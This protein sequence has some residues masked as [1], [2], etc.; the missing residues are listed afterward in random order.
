MDDQHLPSPTMVDTCHYTLQFPPSQSSPAAL[1]SVLAEVLAFVATLS[2]SYI[3]H[4]QPFNLT[5]SPAP[6]SGPSQG[7][8]LEGRTDC[9]DCVDDEWFVVWL[10]RE[11]TRAWEDVVVSIEDEDGEFLLIEG[12]EVLPRW[13]TPQNATN[14]VSSGSTSSEGGN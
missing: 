9:T 3:W 12:A 14:R 6:F 4:K 7:N 11:V 10:L 13:V 1:S 5:L 2:S 8:F